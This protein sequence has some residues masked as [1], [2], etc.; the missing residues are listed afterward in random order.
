M[1]V[2]DT[3]IYT[4]KKAQLQTIGIIINELKSSGEIWLSLYDTQKNKPNYVQIHSQTSPE[5]ENLCQANDALSLL[6]YLAMIEARVYD[7]KGDFR[8]YRCFSR[9]YIYIFGF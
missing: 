5:D 3:A 8:H 2:I 6:P 1:K 4:K 7:E 9:D